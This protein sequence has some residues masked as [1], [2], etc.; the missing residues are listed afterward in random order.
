MVV[1]NG[2]KGLCG[3]LTLLHVKQL[4]F[5]VALLLNEEFLK[6]ACKGLT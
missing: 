2:I 4:D 6:D 1:W 3:F 5:Y